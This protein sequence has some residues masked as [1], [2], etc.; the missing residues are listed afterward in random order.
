M[1]EHWKPVEGYEGLYEVSSLGLVRSIDRIVT[2]LCRWGTPTNRT[3]KGKDIARFHDSH[4]YPCVGLSKEGK[5]TQ[6]LLHRLVAQAFLPNPNDF[7]VVMHLDDC[8][9]NACVSN[10][11]WGTKQD[12]ED[13]KV[14]KGRQSLGSRNGR[15][16]LTEGCVSEIRDALR[17]GLTQKGLAD[18]FGV[19]QQ[20]IN[21][22]KSGATWNHI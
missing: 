17:S 5:V 22:I 18:T 15:A 8:P 2:A 9:D 14:I 13:D 20:T 1:D 7:P 21:A 10:L 3:Y 6:Y 16:K 11:R 12:N 19:C 4:G